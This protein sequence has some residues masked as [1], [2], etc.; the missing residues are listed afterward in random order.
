M[1]EPTVGP[2]FAVHHR[3]DGRRQLIELYGE[4]DVLPVPMSSRG[5]GG[6]RADS[7]PGVQWQQMAA[8]RASGDG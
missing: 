6:L 2:P 5:V 7:A 3:W 8:G 1:S 4:I